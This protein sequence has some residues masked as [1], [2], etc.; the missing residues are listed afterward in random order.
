MQSWWD[1][2][3]TDLRLHILRVR[4][5]EERATHIQ[6]AFLRW[7]L[8]R[9]RDGTQWRAVRD[10]LGGRVAALERF[11]NVRRE[12]RVESGSWL[13]ADPS[14]LD[15]ICLEAREGLWGAETLRSL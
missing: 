6:R 11:A 15:A 4:L 7:S 14:V 12:W 3:P 1:A 2:L 5:R 8:Y 9:H 13:E 10:H